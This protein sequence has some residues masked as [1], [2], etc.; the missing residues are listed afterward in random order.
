MRARRGISS[1]ARP[2]PPARQETSILCDNS[3]LYGLSRRFMPKTLYDKLW[4]N[5]VVH[6]VH[7]EPDGTEFLHIDRHLVDVRGILQVRGDHA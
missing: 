2:T 1:G 4:E 3:T 5:H 6:V 7:G